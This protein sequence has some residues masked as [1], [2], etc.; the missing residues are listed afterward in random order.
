MTRNRIRHFAVV[1]MLL[2]LPLTCGTSPALQDP[3]QRVTALEADSDAIDLAIDALV[4]EVAALARA[5]SAQ[6]IYL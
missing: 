5:H 2:A 1:S 4:E 6:L 3:V